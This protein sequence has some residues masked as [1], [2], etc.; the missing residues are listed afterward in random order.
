MLLTRFPLLASSFVFCFVLSAWSYSIVHGT[1]WSSGEFKHDERGK[2]RSAFIC[3]SNI[4][5]A[6]SRVG[7]ALFISSDPDVWLFAVHLISERF[8]NSFIIMQCLNSEVLFMSLWQIASACWELYCL[9]H[10]ISADGTMC[11]DSDIDNDSN[12]FFSCCYCHSTNVLKCVPRVVLV[13]F[14]PIPIDEIRTGCYRSLFDSATLITGKED[15]ASNF[16][17]GYNKLGCELI[18]ATMERVRRVSE[19][20]E[21]LQGFISFRSIGGGTGSGFGT[22]LQERIADEFGKACRHE[23]N[24]FPSPK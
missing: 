21:C 4:Y 6:S 12:A 19:Y 11:Q 2:I 17:R 10:G 7:Y 1:G 15:A 24:I 9:E 5:F 22:L 14:E 18:D 13:D 16:A 23:F 3:A 8:V 20:C